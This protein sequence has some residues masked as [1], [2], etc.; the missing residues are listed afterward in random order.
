MGETDGRSVDPARGADAMDEATLD[1]VHRVE[2]AVEW[3]ER[4]FGA[5][6]DAHHH[7]GHGQGLLLEAAE[8]LREAGHGELADLV[9]RDAA[10]RD[11]AAGRWT[12][13]IVD[14]FRAHLLEPCRRVEERVRDELA[15]GVRH[16]AEA[17]QKRGTAE[18]SSRTEVRLPAER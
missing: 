15:G 11:A 18:A 6:L 9:E 7:A 13:Q 4:S 3:I 10:P 2:V 5:L 12:Y 8:R 17:S 16:R 14:E 1:A